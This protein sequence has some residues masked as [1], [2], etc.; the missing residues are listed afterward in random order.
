MSLVRAEVLSQNL[1]AEHPV[2]LTECARYLEHSQM[3][4]GLPLTD[5]SQSRVSLGTDILPPKQNHGSL[6]MLEGGIPV[7]YFYNTDAV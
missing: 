7:I 1:P 4:M 6:S 3:G 5:S 2:Q